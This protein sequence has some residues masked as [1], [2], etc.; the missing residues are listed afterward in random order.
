MMRRSR[1]YLILIVALLVLGVGV[2][3]Y[4][5]HRAAEAAASDCKTPA[6]PVAAATP[7]PNL[8]GFTV[9]PPCGTGSDKPLP[10]NRKR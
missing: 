8:P 7:P 3:V 9:E 5:R 1:W 6:A 2:A 4:A 10:V